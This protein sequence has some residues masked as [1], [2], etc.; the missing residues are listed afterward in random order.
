MSATAAGVGAMAFAGNA[1]ALT[2][3]GG[4]GSNDGGSGGSDGGE[5]EPS[6]VDVL[7]YALTLEH[8]E[9]TFYEQGLEEFSASELQSAETLCQR[10][11][12]LNA[13]VPTR[14]ESIGAHEQAHVDQLEAVIEKLGGE[15]VEAA[16]YDFGYET[17]SDFLKV[18]QVLENTGVSAYNGAIH[19]FDN[20]KLATAGATIATVE[21]R[22]A[23]F[24]NTINHGGKG[25]F[26]NSF[27][28]ARSMEEVKEAA[29][30]FIV[31]CEDN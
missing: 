1:S 19:F 6:N 5:E 27:D 22:H 20:D 28:K 10:N 16:C 9:N 31:Q 29:S 30:Q 24:L 14:I 7:N 26:P 2:Q 17:P 4:S 15:P 21:A 13:D 3:D 12:G 8:L 25:P 11:E 18:G 23:S